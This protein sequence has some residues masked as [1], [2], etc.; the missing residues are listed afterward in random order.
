MIMSTDFKEIVD[1]YF[2]AHRAKKEAE[3]LEKVWRQRILDNRP[4]LKT[5]SGT[6]KLEGNHH[7]IEAKREPRFKIKEEVCRGSS[8][9][10]DAIDDGKL[11]EV[12]R[13]LQLTLDTN[14]FTTLCEILKKAGRAELIDTAEM[15]YDLQIKN[16]K[17]LEEL[18]DIRKRIGLDK[19][20]FIEDVGVLKFFP[21]KN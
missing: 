10:N 1:Q 21:V 18:Q 4:D 16:A 13:T 15:K 6:F 17:L 14:G 12:R 5:C 20:Y 19:D 11:P 9:I 7:S 3:E 8:V 2:E